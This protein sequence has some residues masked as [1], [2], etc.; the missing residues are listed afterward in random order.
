MAFAA[1]LGISA[2]STPISSRVVGHRFQQPI[3]NRRT[4]RLRIAIELQNMGHDIN[5]SESGMI[6]RHGTGYR[7]VKNR[8]H[9][10]QTFVADPQFAR[11]H[12]A[13]EHHAAVHLRTGFGDGQHARQWQGR[14]YHFFAA[15]NSRPSWSAGTPAQIAL[16]ESSTLPPPTAKTASTF[17]RRARLIPSRTRPRRGIGA[18]AAKLHHRHPSLGQRRKNLPVNTVLLAARTTA[19]QKHPPSEMGDPNAHLPDRAQAKDDLGMISKHKILHG[20]LII[21]KRCVTSPPPEAA[22][23]TF[24]IINIYLHHIAD[25][26]S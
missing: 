17:S 13:G 8:N 18:N 25:M 14:A 2:A 9:R 12:L 15:K 6:R 4:A 26:L 22:V 3:L 1:T 10:L 7:W 5:R 24:T 23:T 11:R 16:A 21:P 20:I 19:Y